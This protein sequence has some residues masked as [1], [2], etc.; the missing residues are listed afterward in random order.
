MK[1][2]FKTLLLLGLCLS[3]SAQ[4]LKTNPKVVVEMTSPTE[5]AWTAALN[6]VENLRKALGEKKV[7]IELVAHGEGIG[8]FQT[9]DTTSAP[10]MRRLA[11]DGVVFAACE[12]T[13]K[14][15]HLTKKDLLDFVTTVDS[16]VSEVVRKQQA[17]WAYVRETN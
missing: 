2:F 13:M 3:A 16:G 15:K 4:E 8:I 11:A 5:K 9:S 17:G 7:T 14:K 6:H 10:R 12:N 1:P